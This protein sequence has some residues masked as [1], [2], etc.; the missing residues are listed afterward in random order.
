M[1]PSVYKKFLEWVEEE[2]SKDDGLPPDETIL[3]IIE[4]YYD[5]N[6]Y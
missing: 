2:K 3:K 5:W 4:K 6:A 1:R